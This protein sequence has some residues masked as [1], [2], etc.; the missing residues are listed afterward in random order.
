MKPKQRQ[1]Q[2]NTVN[3]TIWITINRVIIVVI[4]VIM[5]TDALLMIT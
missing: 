2:N 1:L 5:I 4:C 3:A